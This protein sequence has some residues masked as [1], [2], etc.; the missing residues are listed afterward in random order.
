MRET[1]VRSLGQEDALEK[2]MAP[3]SSTRA[4]KIPW[5]EEPGRLQSVGSLRVGH[6]RVA[7][8]QR[9]DPWGRC[10]RTSQ[11]LRFYF[12]FQLKYFPIFPLTQ[13]PFSLDFH[14][15]GDFP[16]VLLVLTSSNPFLVRGHALYA[17]SQCCKR[18]ED[19]ASSRARPGLRL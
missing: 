7:E 4:W 16:G 3:H 8:Q 9:C 5:T 14:T 13:V 10:S 12:N 15:C 17:S 18:D 1:W 6:G 2:E 19:A 11:L